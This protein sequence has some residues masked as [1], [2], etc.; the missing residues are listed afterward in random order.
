MNDESGEHP[1]TRW[2]T[3]SKNTINT[4]INFVIIQNSFH[5]L[6]TKLRITSII[7][8][9]SGESL[10]PLWETSAYKS[11]SILYG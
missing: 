11:L 7:G 8:V 2:V 10:D 9:D 4:V 1:P 6:I 5:F 3:G